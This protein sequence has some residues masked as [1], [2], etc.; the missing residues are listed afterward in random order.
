MC[1]CVCICV[2]ERKKGCVCVIER[3]GERVRERGKKSVCVI[4]RERVSMCERE[5]VCRY[6]CEIPNLFKPSDSPSL[7]SFL[8]PFRSVP[9]FS[10]SS[11]P[12]NLFEFV[13]KSKKI[14]KVRSKK[15]VLPSSSTKPLLNKASSTDNSLLWSLE[16]R[17][18]FYNVQ[19]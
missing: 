7:N 5:R 13:S 17:L 10:Y 4:E 15:S 12:L 6:S 11:S 18:F 1:A 9:P 19:F 14:R 2:R 3:E 8:R 16:I